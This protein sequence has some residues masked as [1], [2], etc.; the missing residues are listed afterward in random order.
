MAW[1]REYPVTATDVRWKQR[2]ENFRKALAQLDEA[3][4]LSR[5][6]ALSRL[7]DQGLIQH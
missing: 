6:R 2:F 7:E 5:Q 4:A 1:R 3:D